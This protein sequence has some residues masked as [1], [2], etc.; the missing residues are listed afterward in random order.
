MYRSRRRK[1]FKNKVCF[2]V[3]D[4]IKRL[5]EGKCDIGRSDVGISNL[6]ILV[7]VIRVCL[8]EE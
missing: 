8:L 6:N 4:V 5:Y 1:Y 3:L 2:F 7:V